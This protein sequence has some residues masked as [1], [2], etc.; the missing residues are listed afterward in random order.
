M[1]STDFDKGNDD[2]QISIEEFSE[3]MEVMNP[4]YT[5]G[6]TLSVK[7]LRSSQFQGNLIHHYEKLQV[8]KDEINT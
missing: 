2:N 8:C 1:E 3:T 7:D 4:Y 6:T 5:K